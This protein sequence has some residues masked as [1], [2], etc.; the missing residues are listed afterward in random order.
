MRRYWHMWLAKLI[1]PCC[2][3]HDYSSAPSWCAFLTVISVSVFW[4]ERPW[5][6]KQ[7]KSCTIGG[8]ESRIFHN[9]TLE[10]GGTVKNKQGRKNR[11]FHAHGRDMD[12]LNAHRVRLRISGSRCA[13][14]VMCHHS[15]L[16]GV[17]SERVRRTNL[18]TYFKNISVGSDLV[19]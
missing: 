15:S 14:C 12:S 1:A 17:C 13:T 8:W 11:H 16:Q 9:R 6:T 5:R 4:I 18:K 10:C 2:A 3:Q 7:V 19:L